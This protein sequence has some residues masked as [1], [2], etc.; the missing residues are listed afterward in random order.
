MSYELV[1]A[2]LTVKSFDEPDETWPL[3]GDARLE[4]LKLGAVA[5]GRGTAPPGWRWSKDIKPTAGTEWC[6]IPH[7]GVI[8]EGREAILMADGTQVE[9]GPGDAFVV[10]PGHDAWV[11]GDEP[12]VSLDFLAFED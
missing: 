11:V 7:V 2:E 6:E 9:L 1:V 10:G 4:I 3:P 5:I 12:C 8:L